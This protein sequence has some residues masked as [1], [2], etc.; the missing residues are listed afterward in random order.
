MSGV[1]QRSLTIRTIQS[2]F[3]LSHYV[4]CQL[5]LNDSSPPD[6]AGAAGKEQE[7]ADDLGF[8]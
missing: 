5:F 3:L 4:E 7:M 8:P 2:L 6:L 1:T